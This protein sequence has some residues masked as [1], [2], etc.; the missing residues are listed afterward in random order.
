MDYTLKLDASYRPIEIIDS[1]KAVS[2]VLSGRAKALEEYNEEIHPGIKIPSV[3]VLY[4]YIRKVPFTKRC[5]RRNVVWRDKNTCQYCQKIF[6]FKELTLDHVIPK[7]KGGHKKWS[8]IVCACKKCNNIKGNKLLFETNL[9]LLK[10]PEPPKVSFLD[11]EHPCPIIEKWK[12][13]T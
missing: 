13:Y 10:L 9:R 7:S 8:N 11:L 2:M 4:K 1:Y 3:I 12:K 5:N 6:S